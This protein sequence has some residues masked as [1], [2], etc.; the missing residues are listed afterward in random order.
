MNFACPY[1]G[2]NTLPEQ[3]GSTLYRCCQCG[4][5]FANQNSPIPPDDFS[6]SEATLLKTKR[7]VRGKILPREDC[8]NLVF[9]NKQV[10]KETEHGV[11]SVSTRNYS[12]SGGGRLIRGDEELLGKC[13]CGNLIHISELYPC[14]FCSSRH[15][16]CGACLHV[17]NHKPMCLKGYIATLLGV[18]AIIPAY[19]AFSLSKGILKILF[20]KK[21]DE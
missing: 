14:S 3:I 21:I 5:I 1:C 19:T 17:L 10:E 2:S 18:G 16:L 12:V 15:L 7:T 8:E 4:N 13:R 9:L 11:D 6:G 20:L